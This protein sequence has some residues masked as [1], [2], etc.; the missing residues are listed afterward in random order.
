MQL[1]RRTASRKN[2]TGQ[3]CISSG[4]LRPL[5]AQNAA[6]QIGGQRNPS[7]EIQD[8]RGGGQ[9]LSGKEVV[10][11]C[12]GKLPVSYSVMSLAVLA[13]ATRNRISNQQW[14]DMFNR[15]ALVRKTRALTYPRCPLLAQLVI[16]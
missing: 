5:S 10:C 1:G 13:T 2:P 3:T 9:Y 15:S 16:K 6:S 14:C 12:A 11:R 4:L 8:V 7:P